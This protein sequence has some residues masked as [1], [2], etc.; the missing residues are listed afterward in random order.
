LPHRDRA[1]DDRINGGWFDR[2]ADE[3]ATSVRARG[4][5]RAPDWRRNRARR[6]PIAIERVT[7][8]SIVPGSIAPGRFVLFAIV[9]ASLVAVATV[10]GLHEDASRMSPDGYS[11]GV[12]SL[13]TTR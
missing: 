11:S 7:I 4:A 10:I 8:E 3:R 12:V 6:A 13:R 2:R 1:G 5:A 9:A